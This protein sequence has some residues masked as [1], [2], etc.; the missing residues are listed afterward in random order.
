M[1][2]ETLR[3]N[4]I[5]LD[6][7]TFGRVFEIVV[8]RLAGYD[9]AEDNSH[10]RF[11][12]SSSSKIEVKATRVFPK[13]KKLDESNLAASL[14]GKSIEKELLFDSQKNTQPW[15]SGICQVKLNCFD[16][17]YYCVVFHD[18]IYIFVANPEE[19]VSDKKFNFCK[20]QHRHG[21]MGQFH[22]TQKTI[23]H[24]IENYLYKILNYK[25]LMAI[26]KFEE[27]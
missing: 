20:K 27:K 15:N 11:C 26:L 25:Q 18:K 21:C 9:K 10:D 24:H 6:G 23:S 8:S 2:E 4:M 1:Q 14:M 19:I 17:L 5:V 7:K 3:K 22:I 12:V 16:M 13:L